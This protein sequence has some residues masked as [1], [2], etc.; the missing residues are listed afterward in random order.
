MLRCIKIIFLKYK[1]KTLLKL[2][3]PLSFQWT[4]RKVYIT[5]FSHC[6]SVGSSLDLTK[7]FR[8]SLQVKGKPLKGFK[9][10]NSMIWLS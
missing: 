2:S 10:G 7:E 3:S 6:I 9:Q 1:L 8:F 4:T 5:C